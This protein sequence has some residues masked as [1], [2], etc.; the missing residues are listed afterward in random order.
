M[1]CVDQILTGSRLTR[2]SLIENHFLLRSWQFQSRKFSDSSHSLV[3][4]PPRVDQPLVIAHHYSSSFLHVKHSLPHC[5]AARALAQAGARPEPSWA[6]SL[7]PLASTSRKSARTSSDLP[8]KS[9]PLDSNPLSARL[10]PCLFCQVPISS[11][12]VLP[13]PQAARSAFRKAPRRKRTCRFSSSACAC[14][15]LVEQDVCTL[16]VSVYDSVA[17]VE[18]VEPAPCPDADFETLL[19]AQRWTAAARPP[20]PVETV[21]QRA[22]WH[23]VVHE[24]HFPVLPLDC[25]RLSTSSVDDDDALVDFSESAP[26]DLEPAVEVLCGELH[27]DQRKTAAETFG[28]GGRLLV[29]RLPS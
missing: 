9:P 8:A 5:P 25:D 16:H 15:V 24:N 20:K 17:G 19:P 23:I 14:G 3:P 6:D 26:P 10:L 2:W 13:P 27:L 28:S 7:D 4:N 11:K 22:T 18:I 1:V 29:V 21:G 12:C